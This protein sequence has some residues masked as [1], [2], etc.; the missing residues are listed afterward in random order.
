MSSG[1]KIFR[2]LKFM[3][4]LRKLC[5]YF[6]KTPDAVQILKAFICLFGLIYHILDNIVWAANTGI[7]DEF[8]LGE[9]RWKMSKNFFSLIRNMIKL[10]MDVL[11]IRKYISHDRYNEEEILTEFNKEISNVNR[12][13]HCNIIKQTL[14]NRV[15]IRMKS[16]DIAHSSLR[17]CMLSYNLKIEPFYSVSHPV[18]IAFFGVLHASISIYKQLSKNSDLRNSFSIY[19]FIEKGK[20]SGSLEKLLIDNRDEEELFSDDYFDNYYIDF[21]KDIIERLETQIQTE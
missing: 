18:Y 2:L 17:I 3:E 9:I 21:N 20:N 4:D 8:L 12:H 14:E 19:G 1:R 10:I 11:K 6:Y 7:I 16:I 15:K 5:G 13:S